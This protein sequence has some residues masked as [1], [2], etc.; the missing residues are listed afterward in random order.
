MLENLNQYI[1]RPAG[2]GK[3]VWPSSKFLQPNAVERDR[4]NGTEPSKDK[5]EFTIMMLTYKRTE[6]ML[7]LL[8]H[9]NELPKL[10]KVLIIWN[11][12]DPPHPGLKWPNVTYPVKVNKTLA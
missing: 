2:D 5:E 4:M 8:K 11:N 7:R 12:K 10:N 6:T 3:Y 1:T 9:L